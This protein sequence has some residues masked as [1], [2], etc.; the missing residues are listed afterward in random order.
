ML[1]DPGLG[2]GKDEFSISQADPETIENDLLNAKQIIQ[3]CSPAGTTPLTRHILDIRGT[4]NSIQDT[5][6]GRKVAII[7]ATDG[8]PTDERGYGG[9]AQNDKFITAL[10]SLEGLP[11]WLVVR[12]C[13]DDDRVVAFYNG[14]DSQL[15]MSV[16]VLD[17]Y[18]SEAREVYRKNRWINYTLPLHRCREMGYDNRLFDT[19]DER[20]LIKGEIRQFCQLILGDDVIDGVPD[21]DVDWDAFL[22]SLQRALGNESLQY[23][24]I[25]SCMCP[26]LDVVQMKK[27]Y[28]QGPS[29]LFILSVI[30]IILALMLPS[31]FDI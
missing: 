1:N 13:T 19:M 26:V 7:I 14:L 25:R 20:M 16:E 2:F 6:Q 3:K 27:A 29:P 9:P 21:P 8:L 31:I 5:L 18:I 30:V 24:P 12:L 15:E 23:N 4:V 10:R 17:D 11:V 22:D 28:G